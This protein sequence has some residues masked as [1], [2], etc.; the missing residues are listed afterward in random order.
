M[1]HQQAH[2]H[3]E[4][5]RTMKILVISGPN[6][7]M[8]GKRESKH[9][10]SIT[11]EQINNNLKSLAKSLGASLSFFQS[12]LEGEIIDFLQNEASRKADG[13]LINP[14]ALTHYGYSLRD[15]LVD[16]NLPI[17]EVHLSNIDNR[18][19]FRKV[20]VL[21]GIVSER[22]MGLK[23]KS[24]FIGLEKLVAHLKKT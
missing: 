19:S 13:I 20:D 17:V 1:I 11:L 12:N 24:Y 21:D 15:A 22:I 7:N 14:G 3:G 8:L 6:L 10:G 4:R 5:S 2:D 23:E 9:Y 16:T 18:E